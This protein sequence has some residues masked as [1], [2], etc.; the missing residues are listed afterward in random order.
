MTVHDLSLNTA[1]CAASK[2]QTRP[3]T[4]PLPETA[5]KP[6]RQHC[7]VAH[8]EQVANCCLKN[9]MKAGFSSHLKLSLTKPSCQGISAL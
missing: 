1:V 3:T 7:S 8:E 9:Y 5:R 6:W 2:A 4:F